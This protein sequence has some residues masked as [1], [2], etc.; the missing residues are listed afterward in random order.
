MVFRFYRKAELLA[1]R[2][3]PM[4]EVAQKLEKALEWEGPLEKNGAVRVQ[5]G[6][7]KPWDLARL[8]KWLQKRGGK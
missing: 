8:K 5:V 2:E 7:W 1:E 3:V 6:S 4:A